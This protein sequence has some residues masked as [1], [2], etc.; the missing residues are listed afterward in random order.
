MDGFLCTPFPALFWIERENSKKQS[1]AIEW[2]MY[3]Q[4]IGWMD[5]WMHAQSPVY[6]CGK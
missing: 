3:V 5:G 1:R 2:R 4:Y 6:M